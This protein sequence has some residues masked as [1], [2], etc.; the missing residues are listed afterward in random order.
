M[1]SIYLYDLPLDYYQT[2]PGRINAI[3]TNDVL[4][5]AK[6]HLVPERMVVVAVGDRSKIES[7]IAK[8]NLGTIAYRDADGKEMA[9]GTGA[10]SSSPGGSN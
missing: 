2:L 9:A 6:K 5:V 8:L 10:S 3:T 1:A 7:Q 4:D